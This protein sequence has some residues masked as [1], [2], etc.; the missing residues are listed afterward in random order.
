MS[1]TEYELA[2]VD[3]AVQLLDY[4]GQKSW[5]L[6]IDLNTLDLG[7]VKNCILGQIYGNYDATGAHAFR[8]VECAAC[9]K[10]GDVDDA[11]NS[12]TY[13]DAWRE[14]LAPGEDFTVQTDTDGGDV[15]YGTINKN[16][17]AVKLSEYTDLGVTRV[18][19]RDQNGRSDITLNNFSAAFTKEKPTKYVVGGLYTPKTR[20]GARGITTGTLIFVCVDKDTMEALAAGETGTTQTASISYWVNKFGELEQV[21]FCSSGSS[22]QRGEHMT[23]EL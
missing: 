19:Y 17:T 21:K 2:K 22:D 14:K 16:V 15:W 12:R 6:K 8:N 10:W 9:P 13:H 5:R 20:R 18:V 7:D 11:F 4:H 1:A 3:K 23:V